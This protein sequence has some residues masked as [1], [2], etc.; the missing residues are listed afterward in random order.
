MTLA[1]QAMRW[2]ASIV[3]SGAI[4]FLI[5]ISAWAQLPTGTFLGVVKDCVGRGYS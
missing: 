2:C 1:T 4:F 3:L 5:S